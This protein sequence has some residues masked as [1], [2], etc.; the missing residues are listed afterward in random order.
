MLENEHALKQKAARSTNSFS[1]Q[2]SGKIDDFL[3]LCVYEHD[4]KTHGLE[5][6]NEER[7]ASDLPIFIE[8]TSANSFIIWDRVYRESA[9]VFNSLRVAARNRLIRQIATNIVNHLLMK[10]KK[11]SQPLSSIL[12]DKKLKSSSILNIENILKKDTFLVNDEAWEGFCRWC[13]MHLTEWVLE[14]MVQSIGSHRLEALE[15]KELNDLFYQSISKHLSEDHDFIIRF[16]SIVNTYTLEW[17]KKISRSLNLEDCTVHDIEALFNFKKDSFFH[18]LSTLTPGNDSTLAAKDFLSVMNNAPYQS[19]REALY[20]KNFKTNE[21]SSWPVMPLDK[22][23]MTGM[24]QIKPFNKDHYRF[25]AAHPIIKESWEQAEGLSDL[26]ADVF[27]ALCAIFLSKAKYYKD[28]VEVNIDDLLS[29]RGLKSK[30]GG[31]GRR[32]GY[33]LKQRRQVLK[34]LSTIQN[35]WIELDK[36]II[37]EKGKPVETKLE[38]RAF[39]FVDQERQDCR[40]TEEMNE[41]KIRYT[42]DRVF[43]KYLCGSGRQVA[44]LPVKALHYDPYRK[45]W[46]KRLARYLSW[47]WRIQARK[48]DFLQPNKVSTL[49]EA[50]SIHMNERMPSR[51]RDRLEKALDTLQQ[52]GLIQ[53][54]HYEKWDELIADQK[55]WGRVWAHSTIIIDPPEYVKE[56]YRPIKRKQSV[57]SMPKVQQVPYRAE[58]SSEISGSQIRKIREG[59]NLSLHDAAEEMEISSSYLS[60]I[61]RGIKTPSNK[62]QSRLIKWLERF[63]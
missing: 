48:G 15:K 11:F 27:D 26:D 28:I 44:L 63:D 32:G 8:N 36:S 10:Y 6:A 5:G 42:V 25:N 1:K 47:R 23:N 31:E 7:A 43:A 50:I 35:L 19:V 22:G 59:L 17:I 24:L 16:T 39:L 41:K 9:Q 38:G 57:L 21:S 54:W 30:L 56:H 18:T 51:T 2:L 13:R 55:G 37:Y 29:I 53:S 12:N 3:I 62:I 34:S 58:E 45:T 40:I 52:D 14:E 46:E 20:K 60:S 4:P 49:L 61:E 33:E